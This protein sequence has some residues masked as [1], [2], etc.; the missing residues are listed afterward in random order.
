MA[1][2]G[3]LKRHLSAE[4]LERLLRNEL[5]VEEENESGPAVKLTSRFK[6][7]GDKTD[8]KKDPGQ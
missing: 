6:K 1:I 3:M 7:K 2:N 4:T 5:L 8:G